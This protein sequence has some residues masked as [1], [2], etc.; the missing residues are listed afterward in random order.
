MV[1]YRNT[2]VNRI[3]KNKKMRLDALI[4]VLIE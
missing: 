3:M 4:I 1:S 2:E